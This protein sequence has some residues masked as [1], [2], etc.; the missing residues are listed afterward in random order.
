MLYYVIR[1]CLSETFFSE[2][3]SPTF[4]RVFCVLKME[5]W[6]VGQCRETQTIQETCLAVHCCAKERHRRVGGPRGKKVTS[7]FGWHSAS[8]GDRTPFVVFRMLCRGW[9][10]TEQMIQRRSASFCSKNFEM[11][12]VYFC[13][14][15]CKEAFW[16]TYI[17]FYCFE[18]Q[19]LTL[20]YLTLTVHSLAHVPLKYHSLLP[21]QVVLKCW[22]TLCWS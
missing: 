3:F 15:H 20:L 21:G 6:L 13:G 18:L 14:W 9:D 17:G 5:T 19:R 12:S 10:W 1:K 22:C 7:G 2:S 16:W 8:S 4:S 11:Q